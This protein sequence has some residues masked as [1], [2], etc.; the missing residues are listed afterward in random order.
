[1]KMKRLFSILLSVSLTFS[2][3]GCAAATDTAADSKN[4][5]ELLEPVNAKAG[6]EVAACRNIYSS[7]VYSAYVQPYIE[8]YSFDENVTFDRYGA[9]P[10][11][12]VKKGDVLIY[13]DSDKIDEQIEKMEETIK[14]QETSHLEYLEDVAE[15]LEKLGHN[16]YNFRT[17]VEAF[18]KANIP[19]KID[20]GQGVMVPN[21]EF[22]QGEY[23]RGQY[24]IAKHNLEVKE[25]EKAQRIQLYELDH[26]YNLRQLEKLQAE[27]RDCKIVSKMSG[28]VVS[29]ATR[30]Q[31]DDIA[32]NEAVVAV[33]DTTKKR[34]KCEYINKAAAEKAKDMY[35][36]V[37]GKRYE[38]EYQ[39]METEEYNR[40]SAQGETIYTTF[41]VN[42]PED[43]I[44]VGSF[45]VIVLMNDMREN[46]LSVSVDAIHKDEA[47][48]YVLLYQDG[49]GVRT[50]VELGMSD[51]VYTE[52][53]DG[54]QEGDVI[55]SENAHEAGEKRKA[56]EKGSFSAKYEEKGSL[57]Y[58]SSTSLKSGL[59]YGTAYFVEALVENYNVVKKG[60]E[61]MTIRVEADTLTLN[62]QERN[63][64]RAQERLADLVETN[65]GGR[66]DDNIE[67]AKE[68]IAD[69]QEKIAEIKADFATTSIK[70]DRD[71]VIV[72]MAE[73]EED[74]LINNW[75]TLFYIADEE[76]CYVEVGNANSLLNYG[77]AVSIS[78]EDHEGKVIT[79]PG[80]AANI[81]QLG[82]SSSL[83]MESALILVP[84]EY[85]TDMANSL[86]GSMDGWWNRNRFTVTATVRQ[87]DNVL[88]IPRSAVW[89]SE[90]KT[91]V[92]V[93]Q[94]DGS[95]VAT[96]FV[97]GG[98]DTSNYWV[99]EGLEEGMEICLE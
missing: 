29:I 31:G 66:Y 83:H 33:G 37:N 86:W 93:V 88:I 32:K 28:H 3:A 65:D 76:T 17:I 24:A 90:G 59:D 61:L 45:A 10:G 55:L 36:F 57:G 89:S 21:P 19:E 18:D 56:L 99:I 81:S 12:K 63:L 46:A 25:I 7:V 50:S 47:G 22:Q 94:E 23:Y 68:N 49:Q 52:I 27:S 4:T 15:S 87:M 43:E 2:L 67:S 85:L 8:E 91:Y 98:Y 84:S 82:L 71:G 79:V 44:A 72:W 74:S 53:L 73:L 5:I 30:N 20:N 78:Y 62:R 92:D 60:D 6:S 96:S 41:V 80:S 48:R 95:V 11:E 16:E 26:A 77:N 39:A 69:I 40:L 38:A 70:A 14:N 9:L 75:Q 54:L 34:V 42:D 97:A 1:M 64:Q 35:V 58:P 13:S 51:G